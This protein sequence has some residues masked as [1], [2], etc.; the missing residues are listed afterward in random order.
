MYSANLDAVRYFVRNVLPHVRQQRPDLTL[1]VTGETKG[2][3][4]D[5]LAAA[6]GVRFTGRLPEV[7]SVIGESAVCVVPLRVGGGT[8]L[9]V[10]QALA[11]GTPVVA[12]SKGVE[13]LEIEAGRHV[14]VADEP[15]L[16][17]D[18]V[19]RVAGDAQLSRTLADEGLRFVQRY[20]WEPIGEILES[21][22][23]DAR[24]E[25]RTNRTTNA[26]LDNQPIAR[27]R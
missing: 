27:A 5:D 2:V 4:I 18:A 3:N 1:W 14:L 12:T 16:F 21:A 8:R 6:E 13:G 9:K 10:L 23:D 11:L 25:H 17:A 26:P 19:L 15:G 20:A 22:L 24:R 7:E